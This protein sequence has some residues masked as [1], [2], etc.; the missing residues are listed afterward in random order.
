MTKIYIFMIITSILLLLL[1][2]AIYDL[3]EE[4]KESRYHE[5]KL[6]IEN[7]NRKYEI[8]VLAMEGKK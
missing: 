4:I 3:K 8:S 7:E 2:N 6:Y 5:N 1:G